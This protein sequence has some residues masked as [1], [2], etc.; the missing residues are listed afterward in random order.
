MVLC[1]STAVLAADL[2]PAPPRAPVTYMPV[3]VPAYNWS[4]FYVGLNG[5]YGFGTS[6][7]TVSAPCA[8]CTTGNFNVDGFMA[9]GTIGFNYEVNSWVF[10]VEGDFDWQNLRGFANSVTT[11]IS[12]DTSSE[13]IGTL[14]GRVGYAFDRVLV[15]GTGGGAVTD[16]RASFATLPWQSSTELGWTAGGGVEAAFADSW[17]AKVEYLFA[18]F[19]N[20]TC[21]VASCG[22]AISSVKLDESMVRVGV[23]YKFAF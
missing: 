22:T 16:I 18:D 10:G 6:N 1:A 17:T 3:V 20:G 21:N 7:W 14:R 12:C 4:G 8:P 2:P 5:G 13:W 15:Y 23:N 9:G 19:Q 11:C